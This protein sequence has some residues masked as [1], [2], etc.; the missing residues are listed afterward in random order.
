LIG[1]PFGLINMVFLGWFFGMQKT[2]SVM[3]QLIIINF[4]NIIFSIYF[5]VIL[6]LGIYG[7][8]IGSVIAQF[9]GLLISILMFSNFYKNL[10]FQKFNLKKII[11]FQNFSPLFLI[12]KNL[13]L[14]TFFLVFVQA[15]LIK[16][17]G[18]I[19]V[20]E[21]ATMEILLVI[22][23]L[24]SYSLDAFA[25]SAETLVGNSIGAKN[26]N[27]LYKSIKSSTELAIIFSL[28]IGFI[29]YFFGNYLIAIFTDIKI[30]RMLTAEIWA[31]VII[32][33]FISTLAFQLDGIFI[34]ATL[35]KEMRNSIMIACLIFY[36]TLEFII[37]DSLNLKNLYSCF[38]LFLIIRGIVLTM[39]L[40]RVFNLTTNQ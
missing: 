9:S 12:S 24:S 32:T 28:I 33:P 26:K 1:L 2:K 13:F 25:H 4:A 30:L 7:V 35:A 36:F 34:G 37:D 11:N 38:L 22:F 23:S 29:F 14:R 8:A 18:L 5:S 10:N 39:Y 19:G 20:N 40:K 6:D 15:Y 27:D 16:K 21:L 3:L 31:L 17:S